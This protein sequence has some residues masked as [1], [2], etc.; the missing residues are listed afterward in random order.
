MPIQLPAPQNLDLNLYQLLT[1]ILRRSVDGTV[2]L[3][4]GGELMYVPTN[5]TTSGRK[6]RI[7]VKEV[8]DPDSGEISGV[9]SVDLII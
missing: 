9:A 6:Y 7:S 8:T 2:V 1:E 3:P 5:A 4:I